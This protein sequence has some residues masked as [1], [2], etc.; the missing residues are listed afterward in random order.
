MRLRQLGEERTQQ[1]SDALQLAAVHRG[2]L[3]QNLASIKGEAKFDLAPV[4]LRRRAL[5][6]ILLDQ[7]VDEA[8]C[9]VVLDEKLLREV[10]DRDALLLGACA[11]DQHGLVVL[12]G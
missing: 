2:E 3:G 5:H 11:D 1:R 12:S 4:R 7:P 8:Y 9:A 6:E 10:V